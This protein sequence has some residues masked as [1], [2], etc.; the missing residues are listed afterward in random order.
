[1]RIIQ[2]R[3]KATRFGSYGEKIEYSKDDEIGGLVKEYNQMLLE[4]GESAEKLA[5]SER[6]SAWREM[7]RQ[8]AHE[9]KNPLTPM[10]LSIQFLQKRFED[11]SENRE[12]HLQQVSKTLIEQ[13]NTLSSI[14]TAFSNF[15]KMPTANN[16]ML[17]LVDILNHVMSL[18][19]N[20]HLDLK[21]ELNNLEAA[22]VFVDKEQFIRVFVNL[23][24]NAIQSI[25]DGRL[26]QIIVE[27]EDDDDYFK[28]CVIDNGNGIN[29]QTKEKLFYPNFTTKS[30]GMGLGLAI[31]KN[32]IKNAK[33]EIWVDSELGVGS[34]F[35]IRI[36]KY[37]QD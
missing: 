23:I 9:I 24:N 27:L 26:G 36:P 16:E 20:D 1:L 18:F 19:R 13:I 34:C 17:N 6:E 31:V 33:G 15:A 12:E 22:M 30:G 5:Q 25:P 11:K 3:I 7:A 37:K 29:D 4:L 14:A 32:I 2:N 21:L 28:A 35:N 8:I 10:K